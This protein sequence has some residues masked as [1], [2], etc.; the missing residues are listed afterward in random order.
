VAAY[1]ASPNEF[2]GMF[3]ARAT[4]AKS[5]FPWKLRSRKNAGADSVAG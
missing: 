4:E 2:G 1:L 3:E 5:G